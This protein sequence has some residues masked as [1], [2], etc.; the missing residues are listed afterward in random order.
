MFLN[1]KVRQ[2]TL[3]IELESHEVATDLEFSLIIYLE[4]K[5]GGLDL[6]VLCPSS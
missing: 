5:D 6:K 3:L 4:V 2:L 1:S